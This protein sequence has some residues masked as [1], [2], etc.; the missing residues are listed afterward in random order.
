MQHR[1]IDFHGTQHGAPVCGDTRITDLPA[2]VYGRFLQAD[3]AE[4]DVVDRD[5]G[6]IVAGIFT[7]RNG[8]RQWWAES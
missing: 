2:W 4:L 3:D 6:R 7:G 1:M 8:K 5:T